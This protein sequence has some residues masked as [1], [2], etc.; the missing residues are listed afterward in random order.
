LLARASG[1]LILAGVAGAC[2]GKVDRPGTFPGAGDAGNGPTATGSAGPGA[3]G[4]GSVIPPVTGAAGTSGGAGAGG[5]AG[6]SGSAGT[7]GGIGVMTGAAGSS[8]SAGAFGAA[9]AG[10]G[11]AG[12]GGYSDGGASDGGGGDASA[13]C[14]VT[15][16]R[17]D[18]GSF[19]GLVA[20]PGEVLRV[21]ATATGYLGTAKWDWTIT[22]VGQKTTTLLDAGSTIDIELATPGDYRIRADVEGVPEC[23]RG[24]AFPFVVDEPGPPSFVF[25]VTPPSSSHLGILEKKIPATATDLQLQPVLELGGSDTVR[26]VDLTP[27][28]SLHFPLASYVRLTSPGL[29]FNI[30]SYT[31][32]GPFLPALVTDRLYD[33]LI[34]PDG[35]V[36]PQLLSG[37]L[38]DI[39]QRLA[40]SDGISI[41]GTARDDSDHPVVDAR[42]L[43]RK[44]DVPSTVGP[45]DAS[46]RFTVRARAGTLSAV[47]VPPPGSGLPEARVPSTPGIDLREGT[48]GM[49]LDMKWAKSPAG[50]LALRV[51]GTDGATPVA[52]ARVHVESSAE[53]PSVGTLTVRVSGVEI[54]LAA[55]GTV[56]ADAMTDAKGVAALGV[57]RAGDYRVTVAP[58]D[59]GSTAATTAATLT[60]PA[61]GL[62]RDV[63]LAP[64]VMVTGLLTPAAMAAGSRVTALDQGILAPTTQASAI[65]DANGNYALALSSSRK[66]E[67]LVEPPVGRGLARSVFAILNPGESPAPSAVPVALPWSGTVTTLGN[68]VGGAVVQVFCLSCLD[69]KLPVA[70]GIS[71]ADGTL[72][73]LLP[74]PSP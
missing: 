38:N 29:S 1:L 7:G 55:T 8:G 51:L 21:H 39:T 46:G 17:A 67:L 6:A 23:N 14:L 52:G 18:G 48:T 15:L 27:L 72:D 53:L 50:P 11:A 60:L 32:G 22:I 70:Q 3:A 36:A 45:S 20:G 34:I 74:A 40:V 71:Q 57:L 43:L 63:R 65:V 24:A 42:V 69:T 4:A 9:G 44:G 31:K 35:A 13:S 2:T 16:A 61:A 47:V 41:M 66:Y 33:L 49:T 5:Y 59:S 10:A 12:M 28:D 54:P 68:G 30:E 73:L 62:T 25:R 64:L 56:R 19:A 37:P 26:V 58:P